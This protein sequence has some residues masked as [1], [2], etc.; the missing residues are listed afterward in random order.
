MPVCCSVT[1]CRQ[2]ATGMGCVLSV[3]PLPLSVGVYR[4][5]CYYLLVWCEDSRSG[6]RRMSAKSAPCAAP[7]HCSTAA[8]RGWCSAESAPWWCTAE[9]D[10]ALTRQPARDCGKTCPQTWLR[11]SRRSAVYAPTPRPCAWAESGCS[12]RCR[13]DGDG[14]AVWQCRRRIRAPG[15]AAMCARAQ[16]VRRAEPLA[17]VR[18]RPALNVFPYPIG[19]YP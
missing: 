13:L 3:N 6:G 7:R 14:P 15:V 10:E 1:V 5:R 4:G 9:L 11:R 18:R 8:I 16:S 17:P 12:Q 19:A 2:R